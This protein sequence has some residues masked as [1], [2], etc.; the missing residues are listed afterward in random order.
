M[1]RRLLSDVPC[2]TDLVVYPAETGGLR[3][4]AYAPVEWDAKSYYT[5]THAAVALQMTEVC[6]FDVG[7]DVIE[8]Y[9]ENRNMIDGFPR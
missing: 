6:V 5:C 2:V 1:C 9:M 7:R 8:S 4:P 3:A